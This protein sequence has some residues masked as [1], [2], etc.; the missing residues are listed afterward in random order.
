MTAPWRNWP[1][2]QSGC[3]GWQA[4]TATRDLACALALTSGIVSGVVQQASSPGSLHD[5]WQGSSTW[6]AFSLRSHLCVLAGHDETF[7]PLLRELPLQGLPTPNSSFDTCC[8][9][10]IELTHISLIAAQC[11]MML[12]GFFIQPIERQKRV[13]PAGEFC[14]RV[15]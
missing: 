5:V 9:G 2:I 1:Q 14:E 3:N 10:E 15:V 7:R 4:T 6:K 8:S 11:P 12:R 13:V